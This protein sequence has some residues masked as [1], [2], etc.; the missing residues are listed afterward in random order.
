MTFLQSQVFLLLFHVADGP[1]RWI[2]LGAAILW[3]LMIPVDMS[4]NGHST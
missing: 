1:G 4:R 2:Y 3:L